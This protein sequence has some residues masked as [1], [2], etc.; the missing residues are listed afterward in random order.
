M[1]FYL[2]ILFRE[3]FLV[4]KGKDLKHLNLCPLCLILVSEGG[5]IPG[6]G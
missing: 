1:V 5:Q 4:K 6:G 3:E 2:Q